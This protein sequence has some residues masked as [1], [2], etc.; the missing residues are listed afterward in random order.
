MRLLS[1][2][3]QLAIRK[4]PQPGQRFALIP[5]NEA[6]YVESVDA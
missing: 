4:A 6:P 1:E 2:T 3:G 5:S